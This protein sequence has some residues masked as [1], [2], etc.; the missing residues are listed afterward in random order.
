MELPALPHEIH[1]WIEIQIEQ[2]GD[3]FWV[4]GLYAPGGVK[5]LR[6]DYA[7]IAICATR[8]EARTLGQTIA[9]QAS[10]ERL[11]LDLPWQCAFT[12]GI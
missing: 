4:T 11:L 7:H 12:E 10:A 1:E 6:Y 5:R 3:E 8:E 9:Q 2:V